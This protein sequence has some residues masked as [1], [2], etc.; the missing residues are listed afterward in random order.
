LTLAV[1]RASG[2]VAATLVAE[3]R[4]SMR[5]QSLSLRAGTV[6]LLCFPLSAVIGALLH[7]LGL[8][9]GWLQALVEHRDALLLLAMLFSMVAFCDSLMRHRTQ[10]QY[11]AEIGVAIALGYLTSRL[12]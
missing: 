3:L 10:W 7:R 4:A 12:V 6:L 5:V 1:A 9:P 11:L 8:Y 2:T